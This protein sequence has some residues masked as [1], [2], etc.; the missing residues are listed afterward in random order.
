MSDD[1]H[2]INDV[3]SYLSNHDFDFDKGQDVRPER[4]Y[5][6]PIEDRVLGLRNWDATVPGQHHPLSKAAYLARHKLIEGLGSAIFAVD[7]NNVI[8]GVEDEWN[9]YNTREYVHMLNNLNLKE[10]Y[11][12]RQLRA[13]V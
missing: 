11:S 6:I 3:Y 9:Q 12:M 2:T 4:N 5:H 7:E 1:V 13:G 10:L 8:V